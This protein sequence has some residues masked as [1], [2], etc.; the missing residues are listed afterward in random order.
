MKERW[1]GVALIGLLAATLAGGH[2]LC[3]DWPAYKH[4]AGRSGVSA[5]QLTFPLARKWVYEPSQPP[6][7][8]WPEPGKELH[9]MDFDYAF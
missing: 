9:R 4:D 2:A 7:P 6:M 8:A 1:R 5:E 3:D